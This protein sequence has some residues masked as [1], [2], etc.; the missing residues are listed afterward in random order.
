MSYEQ[1]TF[2]QQS[3]KKTDDYYLK[4][5]MTIYRK[6]GIGMIITGIIMLFVGGSLFTYQGERLNPIISDIGMYS[7]LLWLP[8]IITGIILTR[9]KKYNKTSTGTDKS[10]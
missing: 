6:I 10:C 8:I 3:N 7:F 2:I 9:I 1:R 5:E 4:K